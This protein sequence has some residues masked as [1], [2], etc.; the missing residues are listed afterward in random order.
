MAGINQ[1]G[2]GGGGGGGH[3]SPT[4]ITPDVA[5]LL[6]QMGQQPP[7]QM[8]GS[9]MGGAFQ[10]TVGVQPPS[11]QAGTDIAKLLANLTNYGK[12]GG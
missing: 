1:P 6:G 10:G 8:P 4:G 2:G 3:G 7:P 12:G 9:A 11:A 5:R